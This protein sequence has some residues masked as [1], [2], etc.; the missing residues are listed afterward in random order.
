M[1]D[2]S[3]GW[4]YNLVDKENKRITFLEHRK[5]EKLDAFKF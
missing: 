5:H 3:G 2:L 1:K 4:N